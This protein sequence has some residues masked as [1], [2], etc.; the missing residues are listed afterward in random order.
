[1]FSLKIYSKMYFK[2]DVF[3]CWLHFSL[4][5]LRGGPSP[6]YTQIFSLRIRTNLRNYPESL[7]NR[8]SVELLH[9]CTVQIKVPT[10][11]AFS[12]SLCF[13]CV[14]PVHPQIFP[15]PINVTCDYYIHRTDLS[16]LSS[17][18]KNTK[19]SRQILQYLLSL[20]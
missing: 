17:F 18:K 7:K 16:E 20:E 4:S 12:N 2:F 19:F 6:L 15:V 9:V 3:T 11:I 14:F 5:N 8:G 13:P 1:M 10:Q